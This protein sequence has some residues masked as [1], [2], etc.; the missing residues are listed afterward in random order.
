MFSTSV[1]YKYAVITNVSS[2]FEMIDGNLTKCYDVSYKSYTVTKSETSNITR[3]TTTIYHT[4][5]VGSLSITGDKTYSKDYS[6]GDDYLDGNYNDEAVA[7]IIDGYRNDMNLISTNYTATLS[8]EEGVTDYYYEAHD[9]ITTENVSNTIYVG[10]VDN[11]DSA[12]NSQGHVIINTILDK[13]QTYTITGTATSQTNSAKT[14]KGAEISLTAPKVGDKVEKITKNDGYGDY[15]AQSINPTVT[16]KEEGLTVNAYWVKGFEDLS[17]ESF[18]GTFEENTDYYALIDFEAQDGYELD[19][20][21]PDGIKVNGNAPDEVFAVSGGKWNHCIAKIKSEKQKVVEDK[22][23]ENSEITYEFLE[24]ANQL[25]TIGVDDNATF[26]VNADFNL[27]ENGGAVYV[28]GTEINEYTAKNGST[29]ITLLKEFMG[30]LS[31]G[32]HILKIA[33]NNMG[34]AITNFT[35]A[36]ADQEKSDAE[37]KDNDTSKGDNTVKDNSTAN[38]DNSVAQKNSDVAKEEGVSSNIPKTGDKVV[39]WISILLVST[40]AT[41]GMF[42]FYR[43]RD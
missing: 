39:L 31:E 18:Y 5:V 24:G 21:F 1:P 32:K 35:V 27:F 36:K 3:K 7:T 12:Y 37:I 30:T 42:K 14:I 8:I 13:Y 28:D 40:I 41:F 29:V 26:R 2:Y 22:T 25:Y 38:K 43:K 19:T 15:E 6:S 20:L 9:E 10:D 11:L 23:K 16:T 34:S 33:F 17:E 4:K